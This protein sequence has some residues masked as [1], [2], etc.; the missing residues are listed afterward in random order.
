MLLSLLFSIFIENGLVKW[1]IF[2][3]FSFNLS[4]T[5]QKYAYLTIKSIHTFLYLIIGGSS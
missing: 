1:L 3:N 2:L 4:N 5:F